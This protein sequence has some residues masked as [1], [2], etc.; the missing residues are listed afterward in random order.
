VSRACGIAAALTALA[1]SCSAPRWNQI[2]LAQTW[3]PFVFGGDGSFRVTPDELTLEPGAP[4]TG[5]VFAQQLP[6]AAYELAFST[7][8]LS[9]IDF[10]CGMTFPTLRGELTLVLG[11]WG[12]TVCGLSCLDGLDASENETRTLRRFPEGQ[13]V[14]VLVRVEGERVI[15]FLDDAMFLD[16]DLQ[17]RHVHVR[18]EV[19]ACRP[20]GFCCYLTTARLAN[21]RWRPL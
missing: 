4:L 21:L 3:R 11:G 2:D 5:G 16:V 10:F 19:E 17:D 13:D 12:G 7:R 6:V 8:R 9:G 14:H 15:V 1:C 20:F 18:T